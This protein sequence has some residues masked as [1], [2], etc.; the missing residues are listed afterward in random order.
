MGFPNPFADSGKK[1]S[2]TAA[3][4]SSEQSKA[5][6]STAT[7][8]KPADVSKASS[9]AAAV[10]QEAAV[11][12]SRASSVFEFGPAAQPGQLYMRGVCIGDDPDAIQAC[13]WS[14]EPVTQGKGRETN[15][16]Y[17]IEF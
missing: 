15:H 4:A 9:S 16:L 17:R 13:S 3:A 8:S 6:A 12:Q 11:D 7:A 14:I 1:G 5:S 10:V 2:D